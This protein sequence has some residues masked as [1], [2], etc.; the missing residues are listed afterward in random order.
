MFPR[1]VVTSYQ[2]ARCHIS[3]GGILHAHLCEKLRYHKENKSAPEQPDTNI[4]SAIS[5]ATV[6]INL[7]IIDISS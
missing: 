5:F 3:G 2:T 1:H 4:L 6:D 7:A